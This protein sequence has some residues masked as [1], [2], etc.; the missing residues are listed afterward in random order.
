MAAREMYIVTADISTHKYLHYSK[1][2]KRWIH[3]LEKS[4]GRISLKKFEKLNCDWGFIIVKN[5]T[6]TKFD[7]RMES[8]L[9]KGRVEM[10][11]PENRDKVLFDKLGVDGRYYDLQ[12]ELDSIVQRV[13]DIQR[14][15]NEIK[16]TG[17]SQQFEYIGQIENGRPKGYGYLLTNQEQ[18]VLKGYWHNGFPILVYEANTYRSYFGK[19]FNFKYE[20]SNGKSLVIDAQPTE[21]KES[22]YNSF[23]LYIGEYDSKKA[24]SYSGY[25]ICFY[26]RLKSEDLSF[27]KGFWKENKKEG[28]GY[29]FDDNIYSGVFLNNEMLN[30]TST[31]RN[32]EVQTGQFEHWKLQGKGELIT[33]SGIKKNGYFE[34]GVFVKSTEQFQKEIDEDNRKV[35]EQ[36]LANEKAEQEKRKRDLVCSLNLAPP[37]PPYKYI[38][39]RVMCYC[40]DKY[41]R[42]KLGG[43]EN[44]VEAKTNFAINQLVFHVLD[45]NLSEEHLNNDIT[46]LVDL[47]TEWSAEFAT[48]GLDGVLLASTYAVGLP[49]SVTQAF[50]FAKIGLLKRQKTF[51]VDKYDNTSRFCSEK[52]YREGS[53][54]EF[55]W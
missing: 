4:E 10:I 54:G 9:K 53:T 36:R 18:V 15:F 35:E 11:N 12:L 30:G 1:K 3:K 34:K 26:E 33:A 28:K 7:K 44:E 48:L 37:R 45:N 19:K 40:N 23:N 55:D 39:N 43:V 22:K 51:T 24:N 32:G 52:C 14:H 21:N 16:L 46:K 6:N 17:T 27:Y 25:G 42:Y 47:A 41:A 2:I 50:E 5:F 13:F 38:D 8:L 31:L 49:M 29:F 20:I